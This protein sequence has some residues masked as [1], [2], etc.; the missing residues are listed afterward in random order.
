MTLDLMAG[1]RSL[2]LTAILYGCANHVQGTADALATNEEKAVPVDISTTMD[3]LVDRV[4]DAG[5][6]VARDSSIDS[7]FACD[8]PV[9]R[10]VGIPGPVC[11]G[12]STVRGRLDS[13]VE[14]S[15]CTFGEICCADML[16]LGS[17][18]RATCRGNFARS[19]ICDGPEDCPEGTVCCGGLSC[20][21]PEWWGCG[22]ISC[23]DDADC[24]CDAPR[25]CGRKSNDPVAPRD[26]LMWY[27]S[28][29]CE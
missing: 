17:C 26:G 2:L 22:A 23:H 11:W 16:R 3:T 28:A 27:C 13:G 21:E 1:R 5:S 15:N 10:E 6:D 19:I 12:G 8:R 25:C 4:V 14:W 29:N 24:P 7:R 9:R 20:R 18:T